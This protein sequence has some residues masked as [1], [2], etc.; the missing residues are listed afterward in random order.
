MRC[1][2]ARVKY[3]LE[4]TLARCDPTLPS[5]QP[6]AGAFGALVVELE[7][8]TSVAELLRDGIRELDKLGS[9]PAIDIAHDGEG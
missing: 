8:C 3:A 4:A 7:T 2:L 1:D 9:L 6:W 5:V